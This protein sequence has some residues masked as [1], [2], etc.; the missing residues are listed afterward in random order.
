[1]LVYRPAA[2]LVFKSVKTYDLAEDSDIDNTKLMYFEIKFIMRDQK[3]RRN[4]E[5][6]RT[7]SACFWSSL[8]NLISKDIDLVFYLSCIISRLKSE[9]QQNK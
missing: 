6:C 3:Q 5:A 2:T 7:S 9:R 4:G 1:M 8:I